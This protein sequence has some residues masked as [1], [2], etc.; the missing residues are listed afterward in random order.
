M[1]EQLTNWLNAHKEIAIYAVPLFAFLE[2]CVG[3]GLFISG[4]ILLSVCTLLYTQ[5]IATLTQI[6]P[7]AFIGALTGDHSGFLLGKLIGPKFHHTKFALKH[8]EK[9]NKADKLILDYGV[10]AILVG[11]LIPAIRSIIPIITGIGGMARMRYFLFDVL[12]CLIWTSLLGVLV[13]GLD[14]LF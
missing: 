7:L 9:I 10:Y 8:T 13:V 12:A 1:E 3:I 14:Q 4:V 11:R 6:L 2:A 5:E